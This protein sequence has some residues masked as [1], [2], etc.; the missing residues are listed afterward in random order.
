MIH[1]FLTSSATALWICDVAVPKHDESII[2]GQ[3][4]ASTLDGPKPPFV[5][6]AALFISFSPYL[7]QMRG[8][9]G[10]MPTRVTPNKDTFYAVTHLNAFFV[11]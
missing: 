2:L 5:L 10:K 7:V 9:A 6:I 3:S 1:N 4:S 8:N 11:L